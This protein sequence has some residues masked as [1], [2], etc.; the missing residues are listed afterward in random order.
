M[1]ESEKPEEEPDGAGTTNTEYRWKYL[2]TVIVL[3]IGFS[4]PVLLI[5]H[6]LGYVDLTTVPQPWYIPFITGWLMVMV[7]T[8]GEGTLKAVREARK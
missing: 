4:L 2:T 5:S 6:S 7:Y 3:F 1:A 8:L